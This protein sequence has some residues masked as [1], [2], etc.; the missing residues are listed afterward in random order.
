MERSVTEI[1]NDELSGQVVVVTG[2]ASGIGRS[3]ALTFA[4]KGADV[5]IHT[6]TRE[7]EASQLRDRILALGRRCELYVADFQDPDEHQNVVEWA[8]QCSPT[9]GVWVN[10]AGVD[11]L[12][13]DA[14]QLSFDEKLERLWRVDV[15]A[16][17]GIS[18]L[19]GHRMRQES[20]H[21]GDRLVLNVGWDQAELGM[22]GDSGEIF[23]TVKGAVMA[24]SKSLAQSLAPQVRV[25]CL[26][27]GW[28]QTAWG[29][30]ASDAWQQRAKSE[31]LLKRWGQPEDVANT[32][33]FLATTGRFLNGQV[34]SINGGRCFQT[35]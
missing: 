10:N 16:T 32:C 4:Q 34:I 28:I 22:G 30:E 3:I 5:L 20:V 23:A 31:S 26:A 29:Q 19:V 2:A 8:W 17:V 33:L 14:D 18:R 12:T 27:P 7:K 13:G 25:N 35:G 9:I 6:G 24:F 15:A 21:D 11:V 1:R